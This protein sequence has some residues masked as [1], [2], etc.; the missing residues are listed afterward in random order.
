MDA[1]RPNAKAGKVRAQ[2]K[3]VRNLVIGEPRD[4]PSG[5]RSDHTQRRA[6]RLQPRPLTPRALGGPRSP[7][8]KPAGLALVREAER[9]A[10]PKL[11]VALAT[12]LH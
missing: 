6:E 8:F 11:L 2:H 12:L 3:E 7:F 9:R 4:A 10:G 5:T 1:A